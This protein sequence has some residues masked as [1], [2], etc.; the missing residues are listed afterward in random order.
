MLHFPDLHGL[1]ASLSGT[2]QVF[3]LFLFLTLIKKVDHPYLI[4]LI[5][6]VS[7]QFGSFLPL[8]V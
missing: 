8:A 1:V 6:F 7:F 2:Q 3:L 5:Y 4:Q